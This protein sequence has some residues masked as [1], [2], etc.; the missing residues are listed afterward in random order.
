M[1]YGGLASH[2]LRVAAA[3]AVP[4]SGSSKYKST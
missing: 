2:E 1:P 4:E 3:A